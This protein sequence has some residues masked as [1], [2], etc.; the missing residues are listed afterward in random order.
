[1]L[2]ELII[3]VNYEDFYLNP[4]LNDNQPDGFAVNTN[5]CYQS[6]INPVRARMRGKEYHGY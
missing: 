6:F 3:K 2:K 4:K 1:M 5:R